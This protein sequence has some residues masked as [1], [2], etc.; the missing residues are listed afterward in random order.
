MTEDDRRIV[1]VV[2]PHQGWS[3][4]RLSDG[5]ARF[6]PVRHVFEADTSIGTLVWDRTYAQ[7]CFGDDSERTLGPDQ[8][9][10]DIGAY[11]ATWRKFG[12]GDCAGRQDRLER[13]EHILDATVAGG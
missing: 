12:S 4:V 1:L 7:R 8:Q 13:D 11:R 3:Q 10:R 5:T 9:T 6:N 2:Q